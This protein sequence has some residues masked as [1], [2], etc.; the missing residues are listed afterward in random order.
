MERV[1]RF[2]YHCLRIIIEWKWVLLAAEIQKRSRNR[3]TPT[4][5]G[6]RSTLKEE[7]RQLDRPA[8]ANYHE[9]HQIMLG[10]KRFREISKDVATRFALSLLRGLLLQDET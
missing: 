10:R 4:L 5:V 9:S 7:R 6:C 1:S 3:N 2:G 8:G